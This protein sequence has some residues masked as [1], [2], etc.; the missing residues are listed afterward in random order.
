M[1]TLAAHR[2]RQGRLGHFAL[3]F[4]EMCAPMCVG[5]AA[6]DAIY[7]WATGQ[8]G[9]ARP[10]SELPA[11]SL[12]VV[13]FSMTAPMVAW[14]SYRRMPRRAVVEMAAVMPLLAVVLLALGGLSVLPMGDLTLWE[15][16]LMI[17]AMLVPMLLRVDL[18]TG[19]HSRV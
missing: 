17:P 8:L 9:Y 6:G 7:F 14:M 18:Y 11:L 10:F 3:H 1:G 2:G 5:F 19:K 13:T 15:H 12:V 4:F 16:G